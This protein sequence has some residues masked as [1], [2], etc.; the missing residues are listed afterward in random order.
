LLSRTATV[1]QCVD[2]VMNGPTQVAIPEQ[3]TVAIVP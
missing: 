1:A 2:R 3:D